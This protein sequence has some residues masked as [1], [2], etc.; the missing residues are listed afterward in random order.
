MFRFGAASLF[1]WTIAVAASPA[2]AQWMTD[3]WNG[4]HVVFKRNRDWPEPF[5]R[6]DRESATLPFGLMVANG[7]RRQNLLSDYH[8]QED[9]LQLNQAGELKLR[10][11]LTQMPPQRRTVFV[12]RGDTP[13]VTAARMDKVHRSA[14]RML[15]PGAVP[16]IVESDLPNDGWPADEIDSITKG[17]NNSR[18][19]PRFSS[20][21]G[22]GG[23]GGGGGGSGG[24]GAGR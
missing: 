18:P 3:F 2:Q 14:A 6:A 16:E 13:E 7:W 4:Q 8:F 20:S 21:S 15:A 10:Y 9:T 23:S 22:G 19:Q 24:S 17:F 5:L 1:V 11:I 12:Q